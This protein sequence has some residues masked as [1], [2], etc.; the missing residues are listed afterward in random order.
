MTQGLK[1]F[2]LSRVPGRKRGQAGQEGLEEQ[3]LRA[4]KEREV[5]WE[6]MTVGQRANAWGWVV[7]GVRGQH[8]ML[9]KEAGSP[10]VSGLE[11]RLEAGLL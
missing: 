3:R 6:A 8:S 10:V 11:D 1:P 7:G 2:K 4:K 9:Q 5:L